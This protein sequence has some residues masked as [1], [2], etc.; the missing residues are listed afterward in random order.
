MKYIEIDMKK[1]IWIRIL[2]EKQRKTAMYSFHMLS[3]ISIITE[4]KS[5]LVILFKTLSSFKIVQGH[6]SH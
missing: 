4:D 6:I 5:K 1:T 2:P 3:N